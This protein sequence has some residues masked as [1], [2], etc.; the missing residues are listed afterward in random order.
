MQLTPTLKDIL[1]AAV[2]APSADNHHR[3]V[4]ELTT[5]GLRLLTEPGRLAGLSAYKRTLDLVSLGAVVENISLRASAHGLAASVDL[6]PHEQTDVVAD[7]RFGPL[8]GEADGLQQAIPIRHTNRRLFTG[9]QVAPAI[10][11]EISAAAS[12]IPGCTLDWLDDAEQR[13]KALRMIRA[14][15]GERFRNRILH[16]ELFESIRFDV[17]WRQSC[18][19][20]L[21]PGALE[22]EAPLRVFFALMKHWP[23]MAAMNLIGAYKQLAWRA[24]DLPCRWSPH[25]A[26]ISAPSLADRDQIAAGRAFQRAWLMVARHGL[27]LQPMPASVLYAQAGAV[28]QGIPAALQARLHAGWDELQPGRTPLMVFRMGRAKAP[29]LVAGRYPLAHYLKA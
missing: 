2:L 11:Q 22:I 10:R 17:G 13:S 26:V 5:D 21:P 23:V 4:F 3:L 12:R 27:A 20:A 9:P 28:S 24:G 29:S 18:E 15:E 16:A 1:Q 14:A 6:F 25:L 7:I 19:E 8:P